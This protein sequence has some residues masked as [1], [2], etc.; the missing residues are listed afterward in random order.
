MDTLDQ[1]MKGITF[2]EESLNEQISVREVAKNSG[3]SSWHFQRIFHSTTGCTV[4]D[5]IRG[6]RLSIAARELRESNKGIIQI[7]LDSQFESQESFT[8][9]FKKMFKITPWKFR[10]E[11]FDVGVTSRSSLNIETL[12]HLRKGI[13]TMEPKI[14]NYDQLNLVGMGVQFKGVFSDK[15]NNED[16]IPKLWEEFDKRATEINNRKGSFYYGVVDCFP[17]E[18]NEETEENLIYFACVEV[19]SFDDI[20]KG[21]RPI[22]IPRNKFAQFS[23]KGSGEKVKTTI[24][25]VYG[26]WLPKSG[27]KRLDG[28]ELEIYSEEAQKFKGSVFEY[29][30]PVNKSSLE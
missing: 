22:V 3:M 25:Y 27:Y 23:H 6:R 15:S 4:K 5:Y 10:N 7:A 1:I 16:V 19:N 29:C 30:I 21:M 20:P 14:V 12:N 18:D 17:T 9:A 8:R 26:T 28:A 24:Q 11:T 13:I 2:I